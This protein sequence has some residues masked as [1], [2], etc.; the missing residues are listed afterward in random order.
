MSAGRLDRPGGHGWPRRAGSGVQ[1]VR[2]DGRPG[3][4]PGNDIAGYCGIG[5]GAAVIFG[6]RYPGLPVPGDAA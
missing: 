2:F 4:H 6:K 5:V 3:L 1:V